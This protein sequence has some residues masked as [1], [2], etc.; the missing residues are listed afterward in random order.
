MN[1]VFSAFQEYASRIK[2]RITK[3]FC[4]M[5]EYR[6]YEFYLTRVYECLAITAQNRKVTVSIATDYEPSAN[7]FCVSQVMCSQSFSTG[8][9]YWEAVSDG[10]A[11]GV[12]HEMIGKRDKLGRTEHSWCAEWLGPNKQLSA[13]HRDQ[14]TLLHT[15]KPLK[16][17]VFL[18]L[19]KKTLSFSITDREMLLYTF[20][21]NTS[22]PLY[23]AFWLH[24][25]ERSGSLSHTNRR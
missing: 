25:L 21:I 2:S 15:D 22:N 24:S 17:G 5:K 18:E 14:E 11:V 4:C 12:A 13:W 23:P 19:Q 16:V 20:A 10:W 9:H 6:K 1:S 8:C 3:D 7:T